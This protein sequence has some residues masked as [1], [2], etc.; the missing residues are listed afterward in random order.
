MPSQA[1]E[2]KIPVLPHVKSLIVALYGPEPVEA[3]ENNFM[4]KEIQSIL[5]PYSQ[6]ELFPAKLH[7]ETI[8][9]AL[10]HRIAPY[11]QRFQHAF[12]LGC[13]FEKQFHSI[14]YAH[15]EAQ[16]QC[17]VSVLQSIKNF[18]IRY[19]INDELYDWEA[20]KK[21]YQRIKGKVS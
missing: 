21:S 20:A 7:G 16:R 9:V 19:N 13:M 11:Y 8:T 4:G 5:L 14:L 17:G 15:I 2:V 3:N 1:H 18:Y 6:S 12:D 10:S